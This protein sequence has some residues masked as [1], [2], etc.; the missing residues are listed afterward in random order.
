MISIETAISLSALV[1]VAAAIVAGIATVATYIAAVDTAGAA[2]RAHA[3]GV[4]YE[5]ARGR[6]DIAEADGIVT[7]T[8]IVPAAIGDMRAT[9]RYPIEYATR[10]TL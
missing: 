8:A 1:T 10:A 3:I 2:A 5:P 9:A 7:V 6:V 4:A